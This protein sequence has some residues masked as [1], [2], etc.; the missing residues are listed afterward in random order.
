[1]LEPPK[2]GWQATTQLA[3]W[4]ELAK[5]WPISLD[6]EGVGR[7]DRCGHGV[8]LWLDKN[9]VPYRYTDEQVRSLIVLHL[10]DY[11]A[12]LDPGKG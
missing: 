9:R 6:E 1:M 11:H 3:A 8:I 2:L 7:C 12:D 5:D 10:R 4:Q